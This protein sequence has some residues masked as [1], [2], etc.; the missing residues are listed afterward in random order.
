MDQHI[1]L[2]TYLYSDLWTE[3]WLTTME[4]VKQKLKAHAKKVCSPSRHNPQSI[5]VSK[6]RVSHRFFTTSTPSFKED[7]T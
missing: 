1:E 6:L 7:S 2:L 4:W 3:G 5:V